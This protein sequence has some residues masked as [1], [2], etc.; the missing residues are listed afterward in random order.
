VGA[1]QV[2]VKRPN[3]VLVLADDLG[4]SDIG[5]FGGEIRTPVLD[6]LGREGVR[7][8][9]FYNTA[10]CSP[11]RASLLTGR[12]PHETGI[13]VLTEDL[14]PYGAY[15]GSLSDRFPTIAELLKQAGYATCLSGKWHLSHNTAAPDGSWPT[16]RGFDDFFGIM[17]GADSYFHPQNLWRNEARCDPPG[18]GF[19]LT[20]AISAHAAAFVHERASADQP[21]FLYLAYSAPHWPLHAHEEDIASY[22]GVFEAGWDALRVERY[23][24]MRAEGILGDEA[25]LSAR[26]ATQPAWPSVSDPRWEAR[27][28]ATYAAQVEAMDRG[29]GA[30]LAALEETGVRDDTLVLFLADNGA[31]AEQI[32]PP[33]APRF[34][35]RQPSATPDG[36]PMA[37]GNKPN[38]IPGPDDSFASYGRAWANLSNTPFRFYKRWVHEG[39][40]STPL[41]A[42]WPQGDLATGAI[43]AAPSQLTDLLP[44]LLEAAGAAAPDGPGRSMLHVL[45]GGAGEEH[46]LYFEHVGNAA[47]R[48]GQW[49]AVREADQAWELYDIAHDRSEL[50]DRADDEPALL[51]AL[52]AAWERWADDVGV[53]PWERL[54]EIVRVHGG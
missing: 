18:D 12:H 38:V 35:E 4:Y 29:I 43:S 22:A 49:K 32:P 6:R 1:Q 19:Y 21:F 26:D 8:T 25:A 40:I 51:A 9:A 15:P 46:T 28:M 54:R 44:T 37:F 33:I 53:V 30:V 24:R 2:T 3:I 47:V 41:V 50:V 5:C 27:R 39:G 20:D 42:H 16:R 11:S 48:R 45:R 17:S 34:F 7:C 52:V 13:G 23:Q 14:S 31:C 36:R 10:R